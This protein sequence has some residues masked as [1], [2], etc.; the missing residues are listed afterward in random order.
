MM[1]VPTKI[2][3]P[4][5][6]CFNIESQGVL[7]F[8]DIYSIVNEFCKY[9]TFSDK[10]SAASIYVNPKWNIHPNFFS[11]MG[12]G[13]VITEDYTDQSVVEYTIPASSYEPKEIDENVK[14]TDIYHWVLGNFFEICRPIIQSSNTELQDY[15][16]RNWQAIDDPDWK[17]TIL[18]IAIKADS[19]TA[20][21][22]WDKLLEELEKY[23]NSLPDLINT[24]VNDV[25][26]INVRWE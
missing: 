12:I 16:I 22:L 10:S 20:I 5:V 26:S 14:L 18:D 23:I 6:K 21:A 7:Q 9:N 3:D 17:Q 1:T 19:N 11:I 4:L 15:S 8:T 2:Q 13:A 25:I 24:Y